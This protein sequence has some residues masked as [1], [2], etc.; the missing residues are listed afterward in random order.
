MVGLA[1]AFFG[2][3]RIVILDEP[4]ASLDRAGEASLLDLIDRIRERRH[5]TLLIIS[6]RPGIIDRMDRLL[7]VKDGTVATLM[8]QGPTALAADDRQAK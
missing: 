8:R 5:I 6:H 2:S 7:L 4:D 1:R 3:P